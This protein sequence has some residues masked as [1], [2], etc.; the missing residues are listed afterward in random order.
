MPRPPVPAKRSSTLAPSTVAEHREDRLPDP[1]GGRARDASA[2][3]LQAPAPRALRRSPASTHRNEASAAMAAL[4]RSREPTPESAPAPRRR[5]IA[6]GSSREQRVLGRLKLGS[7]ASEDRAA[8]ARASSSSGASS[9][10]RATLNCAT[11]DWR[12]PTSS[13]SLRSARSISASAKPVGVLATSACS[14]GE[15]RPAP[16]GSRSRDARRGRP[17]RAAGAAGRYRSARRSRS[18]ITVAFG[19]VDPDLDHRRRDEHVGGAGCERGHRLLLLAGAHAAVQQGELKPRSSPSRSRSSSAVAARS[20][21]ARPR[22][23][24]SPPASS[25]SGHTT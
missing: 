18:S 24:S 23:P 9:G 13:P 5:T 4:A 10:R 25:M 7:D 6:R 22:R 20:P 21:S 15:P 12:V 2:R 3:R 16:S 1:V 17:A 14:R 11:P 19:H 8:R